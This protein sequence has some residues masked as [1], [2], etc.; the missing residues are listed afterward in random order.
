LVRYELDNTENIVGLNHVKDLSIDQCSNADVF[1]KMY[2]VFWTGDSI[3]KTGSWCGF[4]DARLL[5]FEGSKSDIQKQRE[6][7]RVPIPKILEKSQSTT[8]KPDS[9]RVETTKKVHFG[10]GLFLPN[11]KWQ[12]LKKETRDSMKNLSVCIW[13]STVLAKR[14]VTG[15]TCNRYKTAVKKDTLTPKMVDVLEECL[16]DKIRSENVSEEVLEE[17]VG[18]MNSYISEK[19]SSITRAKNP[20]SAKK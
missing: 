19:I 2:Q 10:F 3:T 16:K 7:P 12:N 20:K 9:R 5:L 1:K 14:S 15:M 4:Y 13:G 11:E 6:E 17:R 8:S 18:K